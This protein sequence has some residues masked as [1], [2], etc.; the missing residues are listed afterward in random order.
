MRCMKKLKRLPIQLKNK[1]W[2]PIIIQGVLYINSYAQKLP[3]EIHG[4]YDINFQQ[5]NSDTLINA[6]VPAA[7]AGYNAF[8][9]LVYTLGD[10]STGVRFESYLNA[11]NGFPNHYQGSGVGYRFFRYKKDAVD[12]IAGNFYE[13]FGSGLLLRAY[14][15][16]ALGIDNALDGFKFSFRPYNGVYLKTVYAKQ[17][18]DFN[19]TLTN[20][21][22]IVRGVDAEINVNECIDS[23]SKSP[24]RIQ[25]GGA[26]VSKFEAGTSYNIGGKQIVLPQN[27]AAWAARSKIMYHNFNLWGEYA[28]KMNDPSA[29]NNFIYK[30]G[31]ALLLTANYSTKGFSVLL[32]SKY[33]DNMSFRSNRFMMLTDLPINYMPALNKQHSYNLPAT[34]YPYASQFSEMAYNSELNYTLKKK[35]TLGGKYGTLLSFNFSRIYGVDSTVIV[36]DTLRRGYQ[37]AFMKADFSNLF[38]SDFNFSFKRKFNS[39]FTLIYVYY[40]LVYNNDVVQGAFHSDGSKVHGQIRSDIHVADLNFKLNDKHNIRG[41]LQYLHVKSEEKHQGDWFT[42]LVEYSYSPIWSLAV[43]DQFNFGNPDEKYRLHYYYINASYTKDA[44][45]IGIGYGRQRQG[46]FC[47]GGVCRTVPASNGLNITVTH[48]F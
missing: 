37:A 11:L 18:F 25:I 44:T 34:L 5:Y 28:Y 3:G 42:A 38:Y 43:M 13:Q 1:F 31:Q 39:L 19:N 8:A 29:D 2:L 4:N 27:T 7:K 32:A 33:S 45:R 22:G 6:I 17:R 23:L 35:T 47:V 16:R 46:L 12:F 26:F 40:N 36:N 9:N 10:F 20:G 14:E 15:Q 48:T 41:E 30:N 24:L 21:N